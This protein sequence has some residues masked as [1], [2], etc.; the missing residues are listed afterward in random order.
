MRLV[1]LPTRRQKHKTRVR[2][3]TNPQYNEAFVFNKISPEEVQAMGVRLRLYACERLRR[4]HLL[5]EVLVPFS[6]VN[7]TL[8]NTFWLT[9]ETRADMAVSGETPVLGGAHNTS[10]CG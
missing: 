3:G 4:E 9:L 10:I 7:L 6:N 1:L 5:G 2:T 8:G